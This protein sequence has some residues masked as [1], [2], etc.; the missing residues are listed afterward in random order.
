MYM[1]PKPTDDHTKNT[2]GAVAII[3]QSVSSCPDRVKDEQLPAPPKGLFG[4][5][6]ELRDFR[7]RFLRFRFVVLSVYLSVRAM[8]MVIMWIGRHPYR[9]TYSNPIPPK[10]NQPKT[11]QVPSGV[12][13]QLD[14]HDLLHF[15]PAAPLRLRDG[16]RQLRHQEDGR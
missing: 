7:V 15:G 11:D 12:A 8:M 4:W 1:L 10:K 13:A 3:G 2:D 9:A 16:G 5:R 14:H 6:V